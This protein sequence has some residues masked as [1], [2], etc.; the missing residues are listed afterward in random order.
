M[1]LQNLGKIINM[2]CFLPA[3]LPGEFQMRISG[4]KTGFSQV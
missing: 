1:G 4:P 2:G 3:R